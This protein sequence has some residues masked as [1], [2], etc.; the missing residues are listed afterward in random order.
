MAFAEAA[1]AATENAPSDAALES[2]AA[3]RLPKTMLLSSTIEASDDT[4]FSEPLTPPPLTHDALT[5]IAAQNS[6]LPKMITLFM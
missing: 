3:F 1:P 6:A 4:D 5:D 2:E